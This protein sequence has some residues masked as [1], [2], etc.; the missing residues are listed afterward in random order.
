MSN[1]E[2][3]TEWTHFVPM[4]Y[5]DESEA[6]LVQ[7]D[8]RIVMEKFIAQYREYLAAL[9]RLKKESSIEWSYLATNLDKAEEAL[10]TGDIQHAA[11][12][13]FWVGQCSSITR[14]PTWKGHIDL[15]DKAM[16]RAEQKRKQERG[17]R[18][19][20]KSKRGLQDLAREI[21][22]EY[23]DAGSKLRIG[24]MAQQIYADLFSMNDEEIRKHIPE[25]PETI[26]DWIRSVAP[27]WASH[28][29]RESK[30]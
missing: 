6:G 27:A 8:N 28:P 11:L 23:W 15:L 7:I 25:R 17:I 9:P 2:P 12:R 14:L 13:F 20:T 21:A 16:K 30:K 29:G 10:A 5:S 1:K 22:K 24:A 19:S 26:K 3:K 4:H 18:S